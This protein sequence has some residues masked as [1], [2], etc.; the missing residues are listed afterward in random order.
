MQLRRDDARIVQHKEVA[1]P[2]QRR[3]IADE[4][5]FCSLT[6]PDDEEPRRI[7]RLGRAQRDPLLRQIKIEFFDAHASTVDE[8]R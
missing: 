8:E 1:G 7:A 5:V 6:R 4:P 3:E 2:Q